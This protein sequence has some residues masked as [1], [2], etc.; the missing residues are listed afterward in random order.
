[1]II[2]YVFYKNFILEE[3]TFLEDTWDVVMNVDNLARVSHKVFI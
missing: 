2:Q 1:M 3:G